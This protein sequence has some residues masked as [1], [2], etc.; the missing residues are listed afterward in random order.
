MGRWSQRIGTTL[1]VGVAVVA[2]GWSIE[3]PRWRAPIGL[4]LRLS[5]PTPMSPLSPFAGVP[6]SETDVRVPGRFGEERARLYLP[7]TKSFAPGIVVAHGIHHLGCDEPRLVAFARALAAGGYVVLTPELHELADYRVDPTTVDTIGSA[8][9]W[10]AKRPEVQRGGVGLMG[11]SFAGGLSLM[12]AAKAPYDQSIAY[13]L[14]MGAH[15]DLGRVA[16]FFLTNEAPD[17][18]G[19]MFHIQAHRYGPVVMVRAHAE[20]FFPPAEVEPAREALRLWL[21]G[22]REPARQLA[23]SLSADARR[24]LEALFADDLSTVRARFEAMLARGG[25]EMAAVS[26]A[27]KIGQLRM[28]V[29][30]LHGAGD[31]VIPASETRWLARDVGHPRAALVSAAIQHVELGKGPGWEEKRQVLEFLADFLGEG[32][33]AR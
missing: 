1:L 10:L 16:R 11:L 29:Y 14:A 3:A 2:G 21:W 7:K 18:D 17:V 24:D 26:P 4:L 27:G 28:P 13:V 9:T 32:R 15:D 5:D 12:A 31:E 23:A 19:T 6:F 33:K 20:V 22:E 8:A 30:L 25:A